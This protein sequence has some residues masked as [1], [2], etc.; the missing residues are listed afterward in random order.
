VPRVVL[1]T[2]VFV[3]ALLSP[4]GVADRILAEWRAGAFE[5]L[6]SERLF[7][8]LG[9]ALT[10]PG[11]RARVTHAEEAELVA[12]LRAEAILVSDPGDI[13]RVIERDPSDDYLVALARAAHADVIVTGDRHLLEAEGLGL[14]VLSP[15]PFLVGL[16][17]V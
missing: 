14:G 1:D 9:R 13:E 2:N 7:R 5:L 10:K 16:L 12:L 15:A 4:G 11:I 6:V 3:S 8:E 17:A